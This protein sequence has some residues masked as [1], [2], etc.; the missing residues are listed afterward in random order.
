MCPE[1]L[2]AIQRRQM[3]NPRIRDDGE[4]VSGALA[5][6]VNLNLKNTSMTLK[7]RKTAES[8]RSSI[9]PM[10]TLVLLVELARPRQL[11]RGL[12]SLGMP[13][14][15]DAFLTERGACDEGVI[16]PGTN[17]RRRCVAQC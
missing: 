4:F 1:D 7:T 12:D 8:C 10:Q 3:K 2:E 5:K 17:Q 15:A 14:R 6:D 9:D 11:C 13:L 16:M